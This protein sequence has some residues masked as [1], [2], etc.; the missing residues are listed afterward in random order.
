MS[1]AGVVLQEP[2]I[3]VQKRHDE[4]GANISKSN[5]KKALNRP[6]SPHY[7]QIAITGR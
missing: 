7:S 6:R 5:E 1:T 3:A 2:R 4:V